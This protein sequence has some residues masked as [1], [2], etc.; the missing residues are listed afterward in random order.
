MVEDMNR[1]AAP[2]HLVERMARQQYAALSAP[3]RATALPAPG[4]A[5]AQTNAERIT[6][7]DARIAIQRDG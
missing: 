4:R 5:T 2:V 6:S 7:Y 1:S 3:G